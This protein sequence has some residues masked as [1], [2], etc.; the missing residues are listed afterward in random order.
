MIK[1]SFL[2]S[3]LTG[4]CLFCSACATDRATDT[5]STEPTEQ[6]M[7][8]DPFESFNRGV[9]AFNNLFDVAVLKPVAYGYRAV[10]TETM[11]T[12][13]T[14]F[15][16]NLSELRNIANGVLQGNGTKTA[17]AGKRFLANTFWGFFGLMDVAS[18]MEI[19]RYDNDFGQTLAVWGWHNSDTYIVL[20]FFG[21]SNPRD[22]WGTVG[23]FVT[24]P[25]VLIA[26]TTPWT[27]YPLNAVNY[28]QKRERAIEFLDNLHS[29]STDY[30]AT[31]RSMTRQNR[32]KV[33]DDALGRV[34]T[35]T[36]KQYEF[37]MD[38]DDFE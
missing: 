20:P 31:I 26:L 28:V 3:C 33:I 7:E 34:D 13:V 2:V 22:I 4:L 29:S 30:Y 18:N 17:N 19:P 21:P 15:Y 16:D 23:D 32:Q 10:T 38:F 35:E 6:S 11:R 5:L 25:S 37:D 24:P 9:F 8:Q 12:G 1:H 36:P 14:N 27:S